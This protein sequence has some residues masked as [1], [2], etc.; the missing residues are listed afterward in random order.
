MAGLG[1]KDTTWS[2]GLA[3]EPGLP[4]VGGSPRRQTWMRHILTMFMPTF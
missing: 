2:M 3:W 1:I 4:H